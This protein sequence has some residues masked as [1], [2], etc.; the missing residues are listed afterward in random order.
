MVEPNRRFLNG[1]AGQPNDGTCTPR[2]GKNDDGNQ[3]VGRNDRLDLGSKTLLSESSVHQNQG[4]VAKL[5]NQS[6][7]HSCNVVS[8]AR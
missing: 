4:E 3:I 6:K 1:S 5:Q 8:G 7:E 2:D